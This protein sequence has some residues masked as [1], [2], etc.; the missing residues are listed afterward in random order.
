MPLVKTTLETQIL[1]ILT[2]LSTNE[3]PVQAR[4]DFAA[5]LA[6]AVD[7]YVKTGTVNSTVTTTGTAAA[8]TGTA[9]GSIT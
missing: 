9:I 3:D 7:A 4:Q 5:Q 8:Q 1:S 2:N 6:T